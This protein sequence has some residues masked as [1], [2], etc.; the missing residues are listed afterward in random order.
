MYGRICSRLAKQFGAWS[1]TTSLLLTNVL[2][3][4]VH[5]WRS[6][7]RLAHTLEAIRTCYFFL[8]F[9]LVRSLSCFFFYC[10]TP[11][12]VL[13]SLPLLFAPGFDDWDIA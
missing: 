8:G 10:P 12:S 6:D 4:C 13:V 1:C 9:F 3:H 2:S 7:I 5:G 11:W